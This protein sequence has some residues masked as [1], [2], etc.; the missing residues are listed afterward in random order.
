MTLP[1]KPLDFSKEDEKVHFWLAARCPSI[2]REFETLC[3]YLIVCTT[4]YPI[5]LDPVH[6]AFAREDLRLLASK[7][8]Q[9]DKADPSYNPFDSYLIDS[10]GACDLIESYSNMS[11][12][13]KRTPKK[14]S[15]KAPA[16]SPGVSARPNNVGT[17]CF[18]EM[19]NA[20]NLTSLRTVTREDYNSRFDLKEG[21]GVIAGL[22]HESLFE[23]KVSP[24]GNDMYRVC[25]MKMQTS[26]NCSYD[27]RLFATVTSGELVNVAAKDG[28]IKQ[29][30]LITMPFN[31]HPFLDC[32]EKVEKK[33]AKVWDAEE[34]DAI[35]NKSAANIIQFKREL[36]GD[37]SL[38]KYLY[39]LPSDSASLGKQKEYTSEAF[40]CIWN[41]KSKKYDSR[42][43]TP[44]HLTPIP[45]IV[46]GVGVITLVVVEKN[47]K[48]EIKEYDAASHSEDDDD[49]WNF[50]K[51]S[52]EKRA[53]V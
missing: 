37:D 11:T 21:F 20:I 16:T 47:S 40:N 17:M 1:K 39:V 51:D 44:R 2:T 6:R 4:G 38:V 15:K 27:K 53:K 43:P 23:N 14:P 24:D 32:Q 10:D 3:E 46:E 8:R 18:D 49:R 34:C 7:P 22:V 50:M 31:P 45:S 19:A 9:M 13:S 36:G 35:V 30:V 48:Q 25:K 28:T 42:P 26:P 5:L 41:G 52:D 12:A 33:N 29:G